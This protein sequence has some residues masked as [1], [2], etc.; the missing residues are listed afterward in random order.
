VAKRPRELISH[1]ANLSPSEEAQWVVWQDLGWL[2]TLASM[3]ALLMLIPLQ[4]Y[5]STYVGKIRR[6]T[7]ALTDQR[8]HVVSEVV[9]GITAC[10]MCAFP[11]TL[12]RPPR[13]REQA[14]R[15]ERRYCKPIV[16]FFFYPAVLLLLLNIRL[17]GDRSPRS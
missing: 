13:R 10:K 2:P 1:P 8:V 14:G 15:S 7:A 3:S 12:L 16:G 11:L 9:S 4:S 6:E 5:L 17:S